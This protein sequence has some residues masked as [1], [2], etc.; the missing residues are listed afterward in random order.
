VGSRKSFL[1]AA[2]ASAVAPLSLAAPAAAAVQSSTSAAFMR[3]PGALVLSG[4]GARG[5]YE[6]GVIDAL[7]RGAGVGEGVT[8]PGVDVVCG[9]SIGTLNAWFVATGA[10]ARLRAVWAT[11][12]NDDLFAIKHRY[13]AV[14]EPSSGV[15]T[16]I[17]E[18][19]ELERG[20][21]TNVQGILDGGRVAAWIR[22]NVDPATPLIVPFVFTVTSLSRQT[23]VLYYRL[24]PYQNTAARE[25][26]IAAIH[27]TVAPDVDV[28]QATDDALHE[29]IRASAAIPVLFDAVTLPG[30]NG[31]D[32]FI[33]GGIADNTPVDV[34]RAL[35]HHIRVI[36]VD[37]VTPPARSYPNAAAI[38]FAAFGIAQR[39]V[40][41][42]ALRAAIIETQAKRLLSAD[43]PAGTAFRETLYDVDVSYIRPAGALP[44]GVG[45]FDRQDL[46]AQPV[47]AGNA[48]G[49]RGFTPVVT[50]SAVEGPPQ[51]SSWV[52]APRRRSG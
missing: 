12:G 38:A 4:G 27:H 51:S 31:P 30:P 29:A 42:N 35:A 17:A 21:V 28:R 50:P 11:V 19:L 49:A 18:A 7:V 25:S 41:D 37:P 2:S 46:L 40:T 45:D 33:D 34:A 20:L 6:A 48:D 9:S 39:R 14:A 22:R 23:G 36:L 15:A 24:P 44:A 16:R 3:L 1:V 26:A 10:Y 43:S 13:R 5:A 32:Q 8:L 52:A 47:R